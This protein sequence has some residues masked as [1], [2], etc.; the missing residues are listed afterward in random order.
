MTYRKIEL[1]FG[2]FALEA[3]LFDTAIAERF[4]AKLP[5][6][7]NLTPWGEELYGS[8]GVDLGEENPVAEILPGGLAYT[9]KGHFFCV[10]FGQSPAWPV[11]HIGKICGDQWN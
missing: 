9:N 4:A 11:E 1:N 5:C 3:E 10:F 8:I 6:R 2:S 7:V